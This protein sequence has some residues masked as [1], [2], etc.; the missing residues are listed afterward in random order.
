MAVAFDFELCIPNTV[1]NKPDLL[2]T[3]PMVERLRVISALWVDITSGTAADR[4]LACF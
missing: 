4:N 2:R 1:K 3:E